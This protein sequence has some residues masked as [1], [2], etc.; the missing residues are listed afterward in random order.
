MLR[1]F[2]QLLRRCAV[3]ALPYGRRKLGL[4]LGVIFVNGLFQVVGV[5]SIL[6][7]LAIAAEPE[8]FQK[9]RLGQMLLHHLPPMT[10]NRL[11]IWAGIAS[12]A[13]LFAANGASLAG[14]VIR[15]WYGH[16]FGHFLRTRLMDALAARPYGYF[17]ERNS[18]ALLQKVVVD[19]M[20]FITFVFLPLMESLSRVVTLSF[21][22]L[23]VFVVQPMVALGATAVLG[24][25]YGTIFVLIRHS[26]SRLGEGIKVA[27]RGTMIAA[28]QFL[29][30]LKPI[31]VHQK[32]RYFTAQF[33]RHSEA[34]ARLYPWVP[35]YGNG[36]RYLAEPIVFGGLVG[37]VVWLAAAGKSFSAIVPQ[38]SVIALAGYRLLPSVQ[39]LYAQLT[40]IKSMA[41][42]VDEIEREASAIGAPAS[43][44]ER[45]ATPL[46]FETEI[47]L[48]NITFSYPR[49]ERPV[50]RNFNLVLHKNR[51]VGVI[52]TTGSGK[53]TL[54]DI[55]LGLHPLKTGAIRVD[56]RVLTAADVSSLRA[57]VGYVPQ[58][59]YLLDAS[60][61][62][63]IAFGIPREE[64]DHT[65]LHEAA[66]SAQILK[67]IESE[68]PEGWNTLVGER[69][70]RLSGGQRQRIGLAR[71]FY[72]RPQLLIL[73]EA[74]SALD[75][76]TEAEVMKAI[77]NLQGKITLIVIAHRLS[78]IQGCDSVCDLAYEQPQQ[79]ASEQPVA[80]QV[81]PV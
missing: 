69:G 26:A 46:K 57:I 68:L 74:T 2:L 45:E 10:E 71:A 14:E 6:P 41:Y 77:N 67:F 44:P 55:I 56:G 50:L 43:T 78:T 19:V 34:Q 37:V 42:T 64:I 32:A 62:E 70:V 66:Q 7:F 40:Q 8:L 23:A 80:A 25:L 31:L 30:G 24:G 76:A 81:A 35:I 51:S 59:I 11:L 65:A 38:L 18:G 33:S 52:G 49:S 47:R 75:T 73:D 60:I 28:Q 21:L 27:N 36:P 16:G 48:E 12:I 17:L 29:G 39:L 20:Q 5:T 3:L 22:L 61:A 1:N 15:T 79:T 13:L 72:H 58:D 53:T 54:V 9:S 63:N 4:V